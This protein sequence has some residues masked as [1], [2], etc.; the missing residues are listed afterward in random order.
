MNCSLVGFMTLI[1]KP[2]PERGWTIWFTDGKSTV[3]SFAD[4][5]LLFATLPALPPRG[6]DG[7]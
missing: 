1:W 5:P 3:K 4:S 2:P 6:L 7:R